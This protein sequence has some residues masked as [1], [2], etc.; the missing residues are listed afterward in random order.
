VG[1]GGGAMVPVS[2]SQ[3]VVGHL[4]TILMLTRIFFSLLPRSLLSEDSASSA[5]I[6]HCS[7]WKITRSF[8][9]WFANNI[10]NENH[11]LV[12][13][14]QHDNVRLCSEKGMKMH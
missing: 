14:K 8:E 4:M 2:G 12:T 11:W 3:L 13:Q 10:F 6:T 7:L 9:V 5:D 1:E